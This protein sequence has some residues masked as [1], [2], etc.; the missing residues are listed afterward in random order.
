MRLLHRASPWRTLFAADAMPDPTALPALLAPLRDALLQLG[1]D[2]PLAEAKAWQP[3]LVAALQH[4]D[5]PSWRISQLL[6]DHNDWIHRRSIQRALEEMRAL[7]W[8]EPPTG[9]CMLTLGSG[10]RQ[11]SLMRP[12]QNN[13]LIIADYPDDRHDVIDGYFQVLGERFTHT[14]G[15]AG[16]PLCHGHV[17][18]RWPMWRKRL[19]E[20]REQLRLWTADWQAKRVQQSNIL[21][22]FHAVYGDAALAESLRDTVVAL[23]PHAGLF[24]HEMAVLLDETPLALDRFGRV[25][26]AGGDDAPHQDALNL[27]RQGLLPLQN[28]VRLLALVH[29]VR[30]EDSRSRLSALVVR[31]ALPA[32]FSTALSAALGRLQGLLL[33]AQLRSLA[34]G[35]QPDGWIDMRHLDATEHLLLRHDLQQIRPLVRMAKAAAGAR[36]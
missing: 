36:Y 11:E 21:L 8:G 30:S 17:M 10:A 24:L 15:E 6:S 16:F 29:G 34:A 7:G 20:W 18:A 28:A 14:L 12:D 9:Y 13:A 23:M 22:D 4:L 33:A 1:T 19:E 5:L 32:D 26:A 31:G 3:Q 27:E 25:A 35:R 2:P